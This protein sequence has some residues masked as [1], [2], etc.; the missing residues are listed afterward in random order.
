MLGLV[1]L[2]GENVIS[3]S[4]ETPPP[5]KVRVGLRV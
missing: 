3:L 5:P 1:L 4:A 2:R